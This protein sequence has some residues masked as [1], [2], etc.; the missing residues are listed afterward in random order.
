MDIIFFAIVAA[1]IAYKYYSILGK[2]DETTDDLEA[3]SQNMPKE[4][5]FYDFNSGEPEQAENVVKVV[6]PLTTSSDKTI[7]DAMEAIH[8][9]FPTFNEA[10][11]IKGAKALFEML[12]EAFS[13]SDLSKVKDFISPNLLNKISNEVN[14]NVLYKNAV[15]ITLIG[16]NDASIVSAHV[17]KDVASVSVHFITEQMIALGKEGETPKPKSEKIEETW[18]FE[19]DLNENH[20]NWKLK[21]II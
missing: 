17:H 18:V 1:F 11:F 13:S 3:K 4:F 9:R 16:F 12:L 10:F 19:K 21:D 6:Q 5:M 2:K 15:S 7:I 8:K 14:Y 20:I